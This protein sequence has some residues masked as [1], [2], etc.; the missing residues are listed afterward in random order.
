MTFKHILI[1]TDGSEV[2]RRA[3]AT[4]VNLAAES[5]RRSPVFT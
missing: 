5:T 4:G 3:I 1:P 2:S